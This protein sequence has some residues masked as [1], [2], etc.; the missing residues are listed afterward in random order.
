MFEDK[1][2]IIIVIRLDDAIF[3]EVIFEEIRLDEVLSVVVIVSGM[4]LA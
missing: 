1:V 2:L 4:L 3:D